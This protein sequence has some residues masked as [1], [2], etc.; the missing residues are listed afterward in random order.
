MFTNFLK[1][2]RLELEKFVQISKKKVEENFCLYIVA[3][4]CKP[5]HMIKKYIY[6]V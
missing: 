3:L 5:G 1:R 2:Y 6:I 4:A